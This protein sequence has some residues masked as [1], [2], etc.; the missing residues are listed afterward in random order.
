MTKGTDNMSSYCTGCVVDR[1]VTRLREELAKSQA[2]VTELAE[3]QALVKVLREA[4]SDESD[5]WEDTQLNAVE[6]GDT[7]LAEFAG[8]RMRAISNILALPSD[9]TAEEMK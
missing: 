5:A 9:S 6:S 2:Q 7:W 4:L 8:Q 1:E 3:A